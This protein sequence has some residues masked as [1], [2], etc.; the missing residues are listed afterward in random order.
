MPMLMSILTMWPWKREL[1]A[2]CHLMLLLLG[3]VILVRL[4]FWMFCSLLLFL[5]KG[6]RPL[7][8]QV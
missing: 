4:P 3:L 6:S 7:Q 5:L 1:R 2:A 8:R